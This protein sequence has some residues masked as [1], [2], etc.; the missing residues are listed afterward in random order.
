MTEGGRLAFRYEL[1]GLKWCLVV[2]NL[3]SADVGPPFSRYYGFQLIRRPN[4]FPPNSTIEIE[5]SEPALC[6]RNNLMRRE[7][8]LLLAKACDSLILSIELFNR[9]HERGRTSGS[10][11]HLDHGFE[12]LLKAAILHRGG[13]IR[14]ADI[15]LCSP[16]PGSEST[17]AG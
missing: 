1:S 13:R 5:I 10:L 15:I 14:V 4:H 11:I 2:R 3:S 9:P 16:E 17:S 8:K 7:A 6:G 12:M